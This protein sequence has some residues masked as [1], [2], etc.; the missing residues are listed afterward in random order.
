MN[1]L[2]VLVVLGLRQLG[3][4]TE[5]AAT[6]AA[7]MRSWR[8]GWLRRGVREGWNGAVVL[9]FIV[10][11]PMVLV[12]VAVLLSSALWYGAVLALIALLVM[13]MVL[14][15]RQLPD[16]L[17]REQEGWLASTVAADV[18]AQ[19]DFLTLERAA[20]AELLRARRALLEEQMRELFSPLFWF[21]LFGPIAAIA[22][23][24]LRLSA[25]AP[26]S[27]PATDRARQI[28]DYAD[29]PVAR[30]LA[31][32][33]ALAGDFVATWQHWRGNVLGTTG[34]AV[35]TL[36][37][38]SAVAAQPVDLSLDAE[39]DPGAVLATGLGTI[40]ALLHRTLI[41]WV[42]LLAMHTLWP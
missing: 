4:A 20:E 10:V 41:I 32:S 1:L 31:L 28:L 16:V 42:I 27:S 7:L 5:P 33:F 13:L 40:S 23:Y 19:V 15:D 22:Y 17:Q 11:P 35:L 39:T 29:W 36:L 26:A 6:V 30:A 38:E 25:E 37:D 21:L 3:L 18:L 8:D 12:T 9:G 14:L 24:F 2:V 34:T